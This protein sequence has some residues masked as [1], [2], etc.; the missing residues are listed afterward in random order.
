[1]GSAGTGPLGRAVEAVERFRAGPS[2]PTAPTDRPRRRAIAD[3]DSSQSRSK[4]QPVVVATV[5][6]PL[7]GAGQVASR[8]PVPPGPSTECSRGRDP[9]LGSNRQLTPPLASHRQHISPPPP[10]LVAL[11]CFSSRPHRGDD[12][13]HRGVDAGH[14]GSSQ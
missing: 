13:L 6:T 1:M 2:P 3:T 10:R 5:T 11:T 4:S 9:P 8:L 12:A 14:G 7:S